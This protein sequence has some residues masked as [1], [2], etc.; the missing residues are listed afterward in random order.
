MHVFMCQG[1]LFGFT[2]TVST[3]SNQTKKKKKKKK[4]KN[5]RPTPASFANATF[6]DKVKQQHNIQ[7]NETDETTRD[8]LVY[9]KPKTVSVKIGL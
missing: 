6:L 9:S 7:I 5:A 1:A 3:I 4:K 8:S 2:I